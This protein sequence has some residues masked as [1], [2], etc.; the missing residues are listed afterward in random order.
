[1]QREPA[2]NF[3]VLVVDAFSGDSIPVHLLTAECMQIYLRHL[4]PDGVVAFHV[5]N[6]YLDLIPVVLGLAARYELSPA[7]IVHTAND[8][9]TVTPS[10]W[11]LLARGDALRDRPEIAHAST[12]L[13]VNT[14]ALPLWTDDFSDLAS[15]LR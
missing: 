15:R 14:N 9:L 11:V 6:R 7:L 2:G 1:L 4:A 5:S 10:K 3:D 13:H 8:G 12:P